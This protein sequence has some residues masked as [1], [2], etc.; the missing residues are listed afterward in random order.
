MIDKEALSDMV[1][2]GGIITMATPTA[3]LAF[4]AVMCVLG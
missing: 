4:R 3:I 2:Y 1:L